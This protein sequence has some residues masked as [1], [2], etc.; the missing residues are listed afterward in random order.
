MCLGS[1]G[2]IWSGIYHGLSLYLFLNQSCLLLS[3][4]HE[5][6]WILQALDAFQVALQ[7]NPKSTEVSKKIKKISL[8]AKD[9]KRAEEVEIMRSNVDVAKHL[10]I[11]KS[12]MVS[13]C[14]FFA[15]TAWVGGMHLESNSSVVSKTM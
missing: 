6:I 13:H 8:L 12:E 3:V 15:L 2:K 10:S 1:H 7:H 11:V 14:C 4:Y 5:L 9:K